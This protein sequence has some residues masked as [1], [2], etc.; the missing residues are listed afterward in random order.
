MKKFILISA[1]ISSLA[2]YGC[3]QSQQSNLTLDQELKIEDQTLEPSTEEELIPAPTEQT[4]TLQDSLLYS[5][6]EFNFSLLLPENWISFSEDYTFSDS[7]D[8]FNPEKHEI[9]LTKTTDSE[10]QVNVTIFNQS[11]SNSP[12]ILNIS[13]IPGKIIAKNDQF[14]FHIS[15][16]GDYAGMPDQDD[17]KF[18]ELAEDSQ[19]IYESFN[20][21][22]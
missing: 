17:P 8:Q 18:F 15:T 5:N 11:D 7:T 3:I 14:I 4:K 9:R 12:A 20:L 1:L 16:S 6:S 19:S 10:L 2:L 13:D 21:N 22:K